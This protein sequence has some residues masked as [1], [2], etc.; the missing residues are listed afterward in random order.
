MIPLSFA[1]RRY[2]FLHQL[3]GGETWNM[4]SALRLTG[5]LDQ[6]ALAAA[7]R[8]IVERHEILRTTY[9][10]DAAGEPHQR[11]LPAA[12]APVPVPVVDVVP[13]DVDE[14]IAAEVAHA[15][16]LSAEIPFRARL[17]R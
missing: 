11:I 8:D 12:E 3:E 16:D 4:S 15:F 9:V 5:C 2:W 14:V 13:E 6:D 10:T 17:L 7:L 1:Q